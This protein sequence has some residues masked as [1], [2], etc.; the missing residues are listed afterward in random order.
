MCLRVPENCIG[1]PPL[2]PVSLKLRS[3]LGL[4]HIMQKPKNQDETKNS[5]WQKVSKG[6]RLLFIFYLKSANMG[7]PGG[8]VVKNPPANAR[9]TGLRPGPGRSHIQRSN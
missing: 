6:V 9:S 8:A 3:L 2:L 4:L 5:K 1:M 7:L